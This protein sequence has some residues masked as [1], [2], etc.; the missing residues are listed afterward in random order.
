MSLIADRTNK[1]VLSDYNTLYIDAGV[2][3]AFGN[4]YSEYHSWKDIY[5]W[6]P[7][8][9][10]DFKG[11]VIGAE[12][13][14]WG[15]TNNESTHFMKLFIR[16]SVLADILWNPF[17]KETEAYYDFVTRLLAMED[18]MINSGFGVS[19]VTSDYCKRHV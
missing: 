3:N 15:E 1:V 5:K 8:P 9:P 18:R 17:T 2:G 16:S 12:C 14:L 4:K 19:P 10:E 13:P 11:T 6:T 7:I